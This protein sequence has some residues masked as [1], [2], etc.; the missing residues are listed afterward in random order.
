MVKYWN[1]G[2]A[3]FHHSTWRHKDGAVKNYMI[4]TNFRAFGIIFN[5]VFSIEIGN[6]NQS[7]QT[8]VKLVV[9]SDCGIEHPGLFDCVRFLDFL[10]K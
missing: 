6:A 8:F 2:Y 4:S 1:K 9:C 5:V 7:P 10:R 3:T